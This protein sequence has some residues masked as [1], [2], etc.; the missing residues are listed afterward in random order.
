MKNMNQNELEKIISLVTQQ[1]MAAMEKNG[2]TEIADDSD[3]VLVVG[4]ADKVPKD[5]SRDKVL[6][7]LEDYRTHKDIL[8]YKQVVVT[9]LN[10]TQLADIALGRPTDEAACAVTYALLSGVEVIMLEDALT[11][12]RFKDKGSN[13]LYNTLEKYAKTLSVYGVKTYRSKSNIVVPG[14]KPAKFAQQTAVPK[15]SAMPNIGKLVTETDA[16]L[17]IMAQGNPVRIPVGAIITPLARDVF[18]HA[19]VEVIRD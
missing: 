10:I 9:K 13:A 1:V 18:A 14:A 8:R 7:D 19:G 5:L 15:G 12:R 17:L 6:T 3:T 4:C 11:F 16:R 2:C